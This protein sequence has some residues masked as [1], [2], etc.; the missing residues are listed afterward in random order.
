MRGLSA[1]REELSLRN[2][3]VDEIDLTVT[4]KIPTDAA[5]LIAVAPES[6]YTPAEQEMLRQYLSTN[7]GRFILFLAPGGSTF[8]LGLDDLL[9][10]WGI[11]AQDDVIVDSGAAN[12][13]ENGD[14][15]VY[16]FADHPI[17]KTLIDNKQK[18]QF[19]AAR[20]VMPDPG[21]SIGSGL[22]T[23][24]LVATSTTAWGER[25]YRHDPFKRDPFDT[26]PARLID[27]P[28]RL[29]LIVAS[30]RLAVR[31]NLPFSVRGGKMIVFGTGDLIANARF[32]SSANRAIF[33]NAVNWTVDRDLQ[34]AIPPRPIE[35]FQLSLSAADFSQL[36]YAMLLILPGAALLLGLLVYWTRR[37]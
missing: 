18:L 9:L 10:D 35:R 33:L 7:A 4:R 19:G 36:R 15:M 29:P 5:L 1:V 17:T 20:T 8:S 27:P 12:V 16:A 2:F 6:A 30:E 14:L 21:R 13:A 28:D 23:V 25:D 31:D 34:L 26:V 37:A 3:E 24:S 32:E 11:L 22:N